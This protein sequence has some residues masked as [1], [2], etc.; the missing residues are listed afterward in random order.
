[1]CLSLS[2]LSYFWLIQ[3]KN[4]AKA[5][6]QKNNKYFKVTD[7]L[8]RVIFWQ[9]AFCPNRKLAIRILAGTW[10]LACFVI[11]TAYSSVLISYIVAPNLKP[12][13]DS[14]NDL[15]KVPGLK[16]IVEKGAT[17]EMMFL[18]FIYLL[19]NNSKLRV[20]FKGIEY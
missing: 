16:M 14:L 15:P 2:G 8:A 11:F 9:G 13:I 10:C 6:K 7:Y 5:K 12:I 4:S 17:M 1:M 3:S 19:K 18:V 20:F